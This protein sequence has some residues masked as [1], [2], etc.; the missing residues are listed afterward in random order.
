MSAIEANLDALMKMSDQQRRN[1]LAH[2]VGT[3][4]EGEQKC[5][6][7]GLAREGPY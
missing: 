6:D 2:Q 3:M 1:Q 7:K 4:E 5:D